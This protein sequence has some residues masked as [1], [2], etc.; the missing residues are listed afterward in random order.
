LNNQ[1]QGIERPI[2]VPKILL[3][4][5]NTKLRALT[6]ALIETKKDWLVSEAANGYDAIVEVA[7]SKP[8][9]VVLDFAMPGL[10]GL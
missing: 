9:L 10:N 3:V 5:G 4:D 8:D 2:P 6:K 1:W 7:K